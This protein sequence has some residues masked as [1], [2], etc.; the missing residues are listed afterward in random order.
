MKTLVLKHKHEHGG[1][2]CGCDN[3]NH[4]SSK[5]HHVHHFENGV[6]SCGMKRNDSN[7]KIEGSCAVQFTESEHEHESCGCCDHNDDDSDSESH[8]HSR[9]QKSA[10]IYKLAGLNCP[11][12]AKKIERQVSKLTDVE[13]AELQFNLSQLSV[14]ILKNKKETELKIKKIVKDLEPDVRVISES[15]K[16]NDKDSKSL[17]KDKTVFRVAI[18][19]ILVALGLY[20]K[21]W[22]YSWVIF[23]VAYL[24]VGTDIIIR[25]AKN[26]ARRELFDENFLMTIA[27][28]AAIFVGEYPEA[29]M[30]M[31]LYQIGEYFQGRAVDSSRKSIADLM[32]IRPEFA[33]LKKDNK[34][35]KVAPDKVKIN[36]V[37]IVKPGEKIPLDGVVIEGMT[38]IDTKALTGES[39]PRDIRKG[40]DVVSGSINI[41]GLITVKVTKTFGESAV[42][43]ILNLVQNASNKKAQTELKITKFA[44]YYTPI[45]V[46]I[47]VLIAVIPPLFITD[48][49]FEDWLI[50]GA[51]FL[52]VSCPCALVISVPMS[53]FAGLG[54]SSRHGVLVKGGN[55]LE[56]LSNVD[57]ILFDK[58]GTLTRGNFKVSEVIV[59]NDKYTESQLLEMTAIVESQSTHPIA[60]SIV[61]AYG[62]TIDVSKMLIYKEIRGSGIEA[63]IDDKNILVGNIK[64]LK[65]NKIKVNSIDKTGTIVYIAINKMWAGSLVI[66]DEIKDTSQEAIG[67]LKNIGVRELTMLTGDRKSTAD[68]VAKILKLDNYYS[69]LM[70]D[71]KV[72]KVEERLKARTNGNLVFVGDGINDAPVLARADIG[73][74]MGGVGSDAAIEAA[75][76]V[77]MN[78]DPAKLIDSIS[79]AKF[80][81]KI[82]KENIGLA[83]GTKAIIMGFAIFGMAP[84]WLAIFGD[85]GISILAVFNAMRIL[86]KY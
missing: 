26:I 23:M 10:E 84:M 68:E 77:I 36:D 64:F 1:C 11:S 76:V 54:A 52:V 62:G 41:D 73:V 83:L 63:T 30:V 2:G 3:S 33:N 85:V 86:K 69:E 80:T 75:D 46:L 43:K 81:S 12:C 27:T 39:L 47:A 72:Q 25:S 35:T 65:A 13:Y 19:G 40:D 67:G 82:V 4:V 22:S 29:V 24:M 28:F 49:S 44:K 38:S 17:F 53:Y 9:S 70:P 79:I 51:T 15:D 8:R 37:I 45:V 18:S 57:Q 20:F 55:Y 7:I 48:A 61:A 21:S 34:I 6:C 59:E 60:K 42:S 66:K 32:D 56:A 31:L 78:D 58:T 16:S 50:R 74:A 5:G 14:V 71:E